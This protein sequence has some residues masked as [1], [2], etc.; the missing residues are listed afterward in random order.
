MKKKLKIAVFHNL[1]SGGAK[2]SLYGFVKY[3]SSSGHKVDVFIPETANET[4][5]PL[6]E[7]TKNFQVFPVKRRLLRSWAYSNHIH[8]LINPISMK[9]LELAEKE[10]ALTINNNNY[11][12]ALSE[13]DQFTMSPFFL[14][15]IQIP[16][17]YYCQ[18]PLRNEKIIEE[19]SKEKDNNIP[20]PL[21]K[22]IYSYFSNN[23]LKIDRKI[24]KYAKYI[25]VN[26]YFSRESVLRTYGLNCFVS[27]LGIDT[28]LFKPL[29]MPKDDFVLSVGSCVPNKGYDFIIKSLARI[30]SNM[31]PQLII[32][33]NGEDILWKK[34]L[35]N[36]AIDLGVELE[37]KNL[38]DDNKLV[39]LYNTAKLVLYAPYLEPFGLVPIESMGCGTP[40]VAVK[41][42][43]VRETVVHNETGL[44]TDRNELSFAKATL[45][46]LID[47]NKR[48]EM[49]KR[50]INVTNNFWT[51]ENAGKRLLNHLNRAI[52]SH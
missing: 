32:V 9:D 15:Y 18:Q 49:S 22:M 4:F 28:N 52:D 41:E 38:V 50:A 39:D 10:I 33:N 12:V 48:K 13:Q 30:K 23:D 27:Y 36:L 40:V 29:Y 47:H 31:R 6:K 16:T 2:R 17:V 34:Y 44:L 43:G 46:L 1:P 8:P 26:S 7:I 42:G 20:N 14:K 35:E 19:I 21:I 45:K 3:L 11:D 5:L 25:I 24:A 37:I 51:I